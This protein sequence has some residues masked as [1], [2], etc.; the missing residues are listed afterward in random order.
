[1][2]LLFG[3]VVTGWGLTAIRNHCLCSFVSFDLC[4]A[5]EGT[6]RKGRG[7]RLD[8]K[9]SP[10][11]PVPSADSALL[12]GVWAAI[13]TQRTLGTSIPGPSSNTPSQE[14]SSPRDRRLSQGHMRDSE[15]CVLSAEI[16]LKKVRESKITFTR[17]GRKALP[18]RAPGRT[19]T[20]K[21]QDTTGSH[22]EHTP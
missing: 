9:A 10:F 15:D 14:W 20:E 5:S 21:T 11:L 22:A 2:F 17:K 4:L 3:L 6:G 8:R 12:P 19:E 13:N 1:M 7:R 16:P 18:N